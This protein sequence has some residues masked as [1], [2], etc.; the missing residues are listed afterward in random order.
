MRGS[1]IV[2]GGTGVGTTSDSLAPT[3][4][5]GRETDRFA[6]QVTKTTT[7]MHDNQSQRCSSSFHT[8]PELMMK[9]ADI[10]CLC[11]LKLNLQYVAPRGWQNIGFH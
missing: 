11:H 6:T 9:L 4:I 5:V 2:G 7:Q 1:A 3:A 8:G 10:I